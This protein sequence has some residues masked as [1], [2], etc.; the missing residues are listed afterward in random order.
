VRRLFI[1]LL[2]I[3]AFG[4][5]ITPANENI[6]QEFSGSGSTTT[7]LFNVQGKWEVRWN[8]RL[9]VSVAVMAPDGTIVAG[10]AGVLRGSLFV[11]VGGQ[12][13]LK[14]S[15]GNAA[16]SA[17]PNPPPAAVPAI[18]TNNPPAEPAPE[19]AI[20]WH[21]QVVDLGATVPANAALT[22]YTPYFIEPDS[23]VAPAL[24][25]PVAPPPTLTDQQIHTLVTIKGD[26]AQGS[27]FLMH[28][29]EGTFVVTTLHL[30]AANP[31]IKILTDAGME[32]PGVSLKGAAD[33][34]LARFTVA[35]NPGALPLATAPD[36]VKIGDQVIIPAINHN[37]NSILGRL[38]S[39]IGIAP[40]QID[41]NTRLGS[42]AEGTPVLDVKDG[43][44]LAMV[45]GVKRVDLSDTIAQAWPANPAPGSSGI[46]PYY[47]LRLT[48]IGHWEDYDPARF[49]SET[50][51]LK[52]FHTDTH[53]LDS[54]LNSRRHRSIEDV[55]ANPHPPSAFYLN[56]PKLRD[57]VD[58][59]KRF[60]GGADENQRLDATRELLSDLIGIADTDV[61]TLQS[62]N[63]P[64]SFDQAWAQEELAYRKALRKELD[65]LTDNL[66]RLDLIARTR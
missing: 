49:L 7:A 65:D 36:S 31:N 58:T 1:W 62:W 23:A 27:G 40:Q 51:F 2:A 34:D 60:S 43:N 63:S 19:T 61:A 32:V 9:V 22:V 33:R 53:C 45:L 16:P 64:Y 8:A 3:T 42:G 37:D 25:P 18:S 28:S 52:Q 5:R 44:V 50:V 17:D 14:I 57:A 39:V 48:G 26:N 54:Y 38:G 30:I 29:A 15:D 20:S 21:L 66:A 56:N 10:A 24:A 12:Y 6:A 46:I 13:Y 11:P 41:F 35:G 55:E 47:G 4:F 59:Y